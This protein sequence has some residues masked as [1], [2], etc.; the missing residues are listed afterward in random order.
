MEFKELTLE[1]FKLEISSITL[2]FHDNSLEKNYNENRI[3]P[4]LMI[5]SFKFSVFLMLF[6]IMY[7]LISNIVYDFI[8]IDRAT[9]NSE[10]TI[11]NITTMM[12]TIVMETL[13]MLVSKLAIFKGFFFMIYLYILVS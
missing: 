8:Y 3:S 12:T 7:R 1:D 10:A 5:R 13:F 2:K 6:A 9:K 4:L 11:V